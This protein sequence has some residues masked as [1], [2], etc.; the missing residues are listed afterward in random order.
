MAL[1]VDQGQQVAGLAH[2]Q[3]KGQL[4]VLEGDGAPHH[5]LPEVLL[6][7]QLKDVP[8][9]ELLE[10]FVG[11]VDAQLLEAGKKTS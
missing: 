9:E 2:Q 3:V 5:A 4:V 11:Q 6:L 10:L 8:H 7:F 1:L